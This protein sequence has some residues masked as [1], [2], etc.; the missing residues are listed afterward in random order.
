MNLGWDEEG[1][2]VQELKLHL[3]SFAWLEVLNKHVM[4]V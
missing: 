3:I 4:V 2:D 1:R